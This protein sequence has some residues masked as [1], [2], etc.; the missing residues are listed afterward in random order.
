MKQKKRK[1]LV[2]GPQ[3][4]LSDKSAIFHWSVAYN[5]M[6]RERCRSYN[7]PSN[8]VTSNVFVSH[9]LDVFEGQK[10]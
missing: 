2:D 8:D 9:D 7:L 1:C 3:K 4:K 5:W 10:F 6:E